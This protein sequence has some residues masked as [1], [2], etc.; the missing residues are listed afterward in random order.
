MGEGTNLKEMISYGENCGGS[1][2]RESLMRGLQGAF[3]FA[4]GGKVR[5]VLKDLLLLVKKVSAEKNPNGVRCAGCFVGEELL[6]N[7]LR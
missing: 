4:S 5:Q 3:P 1:T 2:W 7:W 6:Q